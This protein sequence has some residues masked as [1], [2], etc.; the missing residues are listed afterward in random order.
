MLIPDR[1]YDLVNNIYH[2]IILILEETDKVICTNYSNILDMVNDYSLGNIDIICICLFIQNKV[3]Q[4]MMLNS[5]NK[6]L[7]IIDTNILQ[8][9]IDEF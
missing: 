1:D 9:T 2:S 6:I 5:K 3:L 7:K 8:E 4:E